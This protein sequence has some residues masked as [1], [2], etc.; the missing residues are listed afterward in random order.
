M[1]QADRMVIGIALFIFTLMLGL[2]FSGIEKIEKDLGQRPLCVA[3]PIDVEEP[4]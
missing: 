1:T 2:T 3:V 4:P